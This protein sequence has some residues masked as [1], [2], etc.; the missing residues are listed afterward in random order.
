MGGPTLLSIYVGQRETV[1]RQCH[2]GVCVNREMVLMR[3]L[4]R[5]ETGL[6][7]HSLEQLNVFLTH[8]GHVSP[9]HWHVSPTFE[10]LET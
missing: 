2:D 9:I 8:V 4:V 3:L 5:V 7:N 6:L 1:N 10:L